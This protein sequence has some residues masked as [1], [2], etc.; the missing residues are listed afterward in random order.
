MTTATRTAISFTIELLALVPI[1]FVM[2][3]IVTA[4]FHVIHLND[5]FMLSIQNQIHRN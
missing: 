5:S 1:P 4:L 3:A 2:L